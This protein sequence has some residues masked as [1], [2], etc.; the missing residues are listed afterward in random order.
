MTCIENYDNICGG[1]G[2]TNCS[3]KGVFDECD[4]VARKLNTTGWKLNFYHKDSEVTSQDFGIEG[5][6]TGLSDSSFHYHSG[7]GIDRAHMQGKWGTMIAL[8]EYSDELAAIHMGGIFA[9]QVT[10]KWGGKNKWIALQSCNILLDS[11]W[12]NALT[13]SHGILSYASS[14]NVNSDFPNVFFEYAIDKK[15]PVITAYIDATTE[16][17]NDPSIRGAVFVKTID[18][19]NNEQF[20]GIGYS[21]QEGKPNDKPIYYNWSCVKKEN[22]S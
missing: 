17:F 8:K 14:T 2:K 21:A 19:F 18:Q 22:L 1:P 12:G 4:N 10:Q 16:V 7:H 15:E 13:T 11:G 9:D 6:D 20:P 3:I 5:G